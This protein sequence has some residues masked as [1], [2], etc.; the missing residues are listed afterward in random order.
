MKEITLIGLGS[1]LTLIFLWWTHVPPQEISQVYA[2]AYQKGWKMALD[3]TRPSDDLEY[4]CAGL[5]FGRDGPI[6]YK[7]RKE[8]EKRAQ[9]N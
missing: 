6:Y 3:V 7:M 2:Q 9:S 4:A 5:W 8:Y 1:V